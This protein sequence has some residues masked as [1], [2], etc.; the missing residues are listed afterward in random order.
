MPRGV[1]GANTARHRGRFRVGYNRIWRIPIPQR[2]DVQ[3][4]GPAQRHGG[5]AVIRHKDPAVMSPKE[6]LAELGALLATGV[7]RH[8]LRQKELA[9]LAELEAPCLSVDTPESPD[10]QEVA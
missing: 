5:L 2:Q 7:Q 10:D 4:I 3:D 8:R 6:R 1:R 9:D